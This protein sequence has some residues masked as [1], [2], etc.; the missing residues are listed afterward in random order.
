MTCDPQT[1]MITGAT[2]VVG[3]G[4]VEELLRRGIRVRIL[5]RRPVP[6]DLFSIPVDVIAGDVADP[7]AVARAADG[8][9]VVYHL[10]ARLHTPDPDRSLRAE[11]ERVNVEGTRAVM[12]AALAAGVRR[13]VLFSTVSVYG[14][15]RRRT[16]GR[17]N[18]T[19]TRQYLR[20][21]QAARRGGCALGCW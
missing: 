18:S 15:N 20:G 3:P 21:D 14:A 17:N 8:A 4:L 6:R 11:Y 10:A 19:Q 7:D 16:C 5:S 13:V 1:A 2:G 9:D 12:K